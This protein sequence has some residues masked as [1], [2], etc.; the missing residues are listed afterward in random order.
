MNGKYA[1][2]LLVVLF[3][4][5]ATSS[6]ANA[7]S[8]VGKWVV[9]FEKTAESIKDPDKVKGFRQYAAGGLRIEM[10]YLAD[11]T[12]LVTRSFGK[13][14]EERKGKYKILEQQENVLMVEVASPVA[15]LRFEDIYRAPDNYLN[16]QIL[17]RGTFREH[18]K[19]TESF[20]LA[21]G[22]YVIEVFYEDLP[23]PQKE[24]ILKQKDGSNVPLAVAGMVGKS[25]IEDDEVYFIEASGI[26][27]G[28]DVFRTDR[29]EVVFID[30]DHCKMGTP[31]DDFL[32]IWRRVN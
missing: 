27:W 22:D 26:Q 19:E 6:S 17:M 12:I 14:S 8:I 30:N 21:Q 23:E 4:C 18:Y 3:G 9:D 10:D 31:G 2:L 7:E 13:D 16:Q 15:G 11:G 20:G 5:G 25:S 1:Q 29:L 32:L 24:S 28:G